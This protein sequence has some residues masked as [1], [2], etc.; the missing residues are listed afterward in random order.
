MDETRA[1][2]NWFKT[3]VL[4]HQSALR[5]RLRR[6]AP[7]SSELDD[8][9]A[10]VLTRAYA[11]PG[12]RGVDHGRAYVFAIA[13]NLIIDQ[14]RRD[15]VVSFVQVVE[16][17]LLRCGHDLEAQ[18]CARDQLRRL[19]TLVDTLP[20]QC[21]RAFLL[22]RVHDKSVAEIADEM[23]LSVST[24]EKHLGKAIRLVMQALAEQEELAGAGSRQ[25]DAGDRG[26]SRPAP[27]RARR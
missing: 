26:A 6:L 2:L 9:V 14:A 24:V 17:D 21:R 4:P 10:E 27:D 22:R 3:I 19:Q 13:R 12:W 20:R 15:K 23:G 8:M 25:S 18:L 11:N 7:R 5:A 16:F 1:K